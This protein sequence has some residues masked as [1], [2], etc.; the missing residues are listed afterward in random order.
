MMAGTRIDKYIWA[1]RLFKTRT[2]ATDACKGGRVTVNGTDAKP[3]KEIKEGDIVSVRKGAVRFTFKVLATLEKRVGA[4]DVDR[5]ALNI[6]P[7]EEL[8]KM[9][10]PVETVLISRDKGSGRPTKKERRQMDELYE[11]LF[12]DDED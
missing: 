12:S 7:E 6:T 11:S 4:K 5:Y 2:D 10:A 3:A 1:I 9:H 8:S